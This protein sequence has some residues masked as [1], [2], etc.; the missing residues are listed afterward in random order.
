VTT[1]T[2]Q[3]SEPVTIELY[4]VNDFHG[5]AYTEIGTI[6]EIGQYVISRRAENPNTILLATGDIFQGSALSNYYHGRP[7]VD[8]LNVAGCVSFTLGNHEFDWG[9]E[10]IGEYSDENPEN[11]E[12]LYTV[13]AA[14]IVYQ[15]TGD[16]LPWTRP[17][18]IVE[19]SGVRIGIIGVIGDVI[20]SIAVSRV[21]GIEFL[22]A[23]DTVYEYAEIL[24]EEE[25]C[26]IVVVSIHG[27]DSYTNYEIAGFSGSHRVDAIFNGHTHWDQANL[28]SRS[29]V[30][31]PYA[32]ASNGEYSVLAQ[33]VLTYDPNTGSVT[34]AVA[35]TLALDDLGGTNQE[36]NQILNDYSTR[37]D[38]VVFVS[39]ILA[40]SDSD[41]TRYNLAPWG[42]SVLRD[43][44]ST[45][46][47]VLNAG[48][49]RVDMEYG[50]V[51]MGD[52][53]TIY[54]FDN[55]IKTCY[56][57]GSQLIGLYEDSLSPN[58]DLVFDDKVTYSGGT[59][60]V[61]GIAVQASDLY[62]VGA[63]DYVFDKSAYVFLD[64]S[65]ITTTSYL[66]RDLLATDL[67]N[68]PYS[69]GFNPS[70]GTA[71]TLGSICYDFRNFYLSKEET[72]VI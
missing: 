6:S 7:L 27:Y 39:E 25:N 8:I 43:Y 55:Y 17:Y 68:H 53:I 5:G 69:G 56:L 37:T 35:N 20:D 61:D 72:F 9:I 2:S 34:N 60:Y 49:F 16:M 46:V 71:M 50:N 45:D 26:D 28:I 13:L 38:Y 15:S 44:V 42:A 3:P 24:R 36:I 12:A 21:T 33:I 23:A 1:T 51:T 64:G 67:R 59:L 14:N 54:P 62:L 29:G 41:Y 66:M 22:D 47:G 63:V 65:Q 70:D 10:A 48:G 11:G 18:E 4:S 57:T 19:T 30:S 52:L 31:L 58:I 32:Q 40:D